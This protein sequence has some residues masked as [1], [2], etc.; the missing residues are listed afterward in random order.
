[1]DEDT[2][3]QRAAELVADGK[4]LGW[5]QGRM[6]WDPRAGPWNVGE[7]FDQTYPDPFMIKVYNV[8]PEKRSEIPAVT[9]VDGTR[10]PQT[11]D[12]E[13]APLY[14]KFID[15]FKQET[16]VPVVLNTSFNENEPI[17]CEPHDA[18]SVLQRTRTD[19]VAIGSCLV[20]K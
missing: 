3:V 7:Y 15:A 18:I 8:L 5:F 19:A 16:G 11:V 4:V 1:L 10:R 9:H 13:D 17:V 12:R 6:E 14:W 2:L 20:T